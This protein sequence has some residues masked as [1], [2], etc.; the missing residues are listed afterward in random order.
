[1]E[2]CVSTEWT[3]LKWFKREIGDG[4]EITHDIRVKSRFFEDGGD[5][6]QFERLGSRP[7]AEGEVND[8]SD[9]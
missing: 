3:E 2:C 7:R 4:S 9:E 6:S 5:S 8:S 1:M